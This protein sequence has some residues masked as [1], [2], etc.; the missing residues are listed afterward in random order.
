MKRGHVREE[1]SNVKVVKQMCYYFN[2]LTE[3]SQ[4][5]LSLIGVCVTALLGDKLTEYIRSVE[6]LTRE[7]SAVF[8]CYGFR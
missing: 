7:T 8:L 4:V 5:I 2:V 3:N 1:R 6:G